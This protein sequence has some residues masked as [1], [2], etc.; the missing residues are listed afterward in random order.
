ML[1]ESHI[2][3]GDARPLLKKK[4]KKE[5]I[6]NKTLCTMKILRHNAAWTRDV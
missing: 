6:E 5:I 1:S 2:F 4:K 3:W